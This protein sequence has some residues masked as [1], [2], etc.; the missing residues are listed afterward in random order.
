MKQFCKTS[1]S[2]HNVSKSSVHLSVVY[3]EMLPGTCKHRHFLS[4]Y[5]MSMSQLCG[6][7]KYINFT[8]LEAE[9]CLSEYYWNVLVLCFSI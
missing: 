7:E 1:F 2:L 3:E 5:L 6:T 9:D 8:G 4:A